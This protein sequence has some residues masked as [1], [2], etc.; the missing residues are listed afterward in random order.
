MEKRKRMSIALMLLGIAVLS[1]GLTAIGGA[2]PSTEPDNRV[3]VVASFYP[4]Y[5]ATLRVAGNSNGVSVCCLTQPTTGCVHEHQLSPA[6]RATLETADVLILNGAG[7]EEFLTAVIP[8][9]SATVVDTAEE[10][11]LHEEEHEHEGHTHTVN[12]HIWLNPTYYAR[13]VAA[14]REALC[15]ADAENAAVYRENAERYLQEIEEVA[16]ELASVAETLP[17]RKVLLFHESMQYLAEAMQLES[18]GTLSI[19]EDDGF[20]AAEVAAVADRLVGQ[21]IL[22]LYDSQYPRQL[23][24]LAAYAQSSAAVDLNSAVT[25]VD[26]VADADV[27]VY[28]MKQNLRAIQEAAK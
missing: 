19:G 13:Q 27:W 4:M 2:W 20:S 9:L 7:A 15:A 11:L 16:G 18:L 26:G 25:P 22:F 10:L 28:A 12:E 24:Q 8:Q 17:F 1:L 21:S 23:T 3:S 5:T 14:I 6:E